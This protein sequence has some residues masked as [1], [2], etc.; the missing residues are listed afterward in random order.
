MSVEEVLVKLGFKTDKSGLQEVNQEVKK[1]EQ[2]TEGTHKTFLK[3]ESSS[4]AFKKIL[5]ELTEESPLLGNALRLALNPISG[6]LIAAVSIFKALSHSMEEAEKRFDQMSERLARPWAKVR[7]LMVKTREEMARK[8]VGFEERHRDLVLGK[9]GEAEAEALRKKIEAAE[10]AAGGDEQE[11]LRRKIELQEQA[12]TDA[13]ERLERSKEKEL[14]MQ[15]SISDERKEHLRKIK[16][17]ELEAIIKAE[18]EVDKE[19]IEQTKIV[20]KV[21]KRQKNDFLG[22]DENTQFFI[23]GTG[24]TSVAEQQEI[25][26]GLKGQADFM[27]ARRKELEEDAVTEARRE[28]R[29]K[30]EHG[31]A[32]AETDAAKSMSK[33][34]DKDIAADKEK[35]RDAERKERQRDLK[36]AIES[37]EA[38]AGADKSAFLKEKIM[39]EEKALAEAKCHDDRKEQMELEKQLRVDNLKL[40][41]A[42]KEK[43]RDS[44]AL[45]FEIKKAFD[46]K[47]EAQLAEHMPTLREIASSRAW[48]PASLMQRNFRQHLDR[49]YFGMGLTYEQKHAREA[50]ELELAKEEADAALRVEGPDSD[51]FKQAKAREESLKKSLVAAGLMKKDHLESI[52]EHIRRLYE[53]ADK[54]GLK[55][56]PTNGE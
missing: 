19:Y 9:P 30:V 34:L 36:E 28:E 26:A 33:Q 15:A 50:Q 39:L 12:R 13:L 6:T 56:Q 20:G 48:D 47:R 1:L 22:A 2:N 29:E 25:L 7:E 31:R 40:A 8:E 54:E 49:I 5:K 17:Q 21:R 16:K 3:A 46:Q 24:L 45:Q 53:K 38:K 41:E 37:A 55:I 44:A 43:A 35:L 32:I 51:R 4:K 11:F 52:D 10:E 14:E 42:E 18:E 27:K 23:K